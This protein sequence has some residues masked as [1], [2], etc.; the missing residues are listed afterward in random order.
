MIQNFKFQP[1]SEY[2]FKWLIY[3]EVQ[4]FLSRNE[5]IR[6]VNLIAPQ[7]MKTK[8]RDK[9]WLVVQVIIS[10]HKFWQIIYRK[11]GAIRF[12]WCD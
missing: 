11:N 1:K 8:W 3:L 7:T 9:L 2:F 6:P 5:I 12:I 10:K 4:T